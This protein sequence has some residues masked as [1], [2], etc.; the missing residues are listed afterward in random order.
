LKVPS[1]HIVHVPG[2]DAPQP[3][4]NV[5]LGQPSH[6]LQLALPPPI[7][8]CPE[9]QLVQLMAPALAVNFPLAQSEHVES[10]EPKVALNWPALQSVHV[11]DLAPEQPVRKVPAPHCWQARQEGCP[12]EGWYVPL[13]QAVQRVS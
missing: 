9:G 6:W 2:L 12:R 13:M 5:P 3:V 8:N 4:R 1:A 11:P 10:H 7:W